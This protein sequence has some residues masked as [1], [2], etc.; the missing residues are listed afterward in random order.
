[1]LGS[2]GFIP[3]QVL[4]WV[5]ALSVRGV[6]QV[7]KRPTEVSLKIDLPHMI[8]MQALTIVCG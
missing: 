3:K 2:T 7:Q 1:M 5:I 4:R 8:N 6:L